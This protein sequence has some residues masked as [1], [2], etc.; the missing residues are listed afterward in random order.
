MATT[1][2][3]VAKRFKLLRGVA[4]VL[5]MSHD[6]PDMAKGKAIHYGVYD[7]AANKGWTRRSSR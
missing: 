7:L 4:P 6:F 2:R 3:P 1:E 5:T